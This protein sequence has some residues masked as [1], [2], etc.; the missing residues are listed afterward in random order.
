MQD[1]EG[2][3][4]PGETCAQKHTFG[5][6]IAFFYPT[7]GT[8]LGRKGLKILQRFHK[9]KAPSRKIKA[10]E[11]GK[12]CISVAHGLKRIQSHPAVSEPICIVCLSKWPCRG[13]VANILYHLVVLPLSLQSAQ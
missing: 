10:I 7:V 1:S 8:L 2:T 3:V 13:F 4:D 6:L 5:A 9:Y 12:L 11:I